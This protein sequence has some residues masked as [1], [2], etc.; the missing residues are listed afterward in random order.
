MIQ[1]REARES[2]KPEIISILNASF[3]KIYAFYAAKSFASLENTL[4]AAD[5]TGLTGV[6][7]WRIFETSKDKIL[8]LFWLAVRPDRRR[9]GLGME[10][11]RQ[12]MS[13]GMKCTMICAAT[14]RKNRLTQGLLK[15]AG[16]SV[17]ER[18]IIKKRYSAEASRLYKLMNLMPWEDLYVW[19]GNG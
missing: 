15:K 6:I 14:E 11:L 18:K 5:E 2:D 8:Y 12:A 13:K 4:V 17:F 9:R 3:S 16:F 7:N 10:L 19:S 1:Y